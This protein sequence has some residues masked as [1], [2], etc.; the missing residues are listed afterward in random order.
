MQMQGCPTTQ[1]SPEVAQGFTLRHILLV[2]SGGIRPRFA[3]EFR[4]LVWIVI[5]A[6]WSSF[7]FAPA[8][9]GDK[10]GALNIDWNKSS[11]VSKTD[12]TLQVVENPKLRRGSDIHDRAWAALR[13]LNTDFVRF[14]LW[15]PYP[16]L[17]VAELNPPE[18]GK[19]F[20]DFS[21]MD[22]LVEDFFAATTGH[23]I[24]MTISTIPQ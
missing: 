12:V 2:A 9:S 20:W 18:N 6:I 3:H 19:T 16:R 13:N 7:L 15:F 1:L 21:Q 11:S 22:P 10:T 24:V 23:P 8:V 14:A 4:R 5:T 17:A